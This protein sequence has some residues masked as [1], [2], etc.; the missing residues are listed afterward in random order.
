VAG[1]WQ[2]N[3][4]WAQWYVGKIDEGIGTRQTSLNKVS[5]YQTQLVTVVNW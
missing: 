2:L 4:T 3:D 5:L 1:L